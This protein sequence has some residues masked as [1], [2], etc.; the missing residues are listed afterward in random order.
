MTSD[1]PPT[2]RAWSYK[3]RGPLPEV[4][5]LTT[6]TPTPNAKTNLAP[7][8]VLIKIAYT[9]LTPSTSNLIP[10]LPN[11]THT[12]P[13]IPELE[14]SGKIVALGSNV[15][16]VRPEL[17]L[18]TPVFGITS[19]QLYFKGHGTLADYCPCP[20][21]RLSVLPSG[22]SMRD[23]AALAGN[24]VTAVQV[25]QAVL[26]KRGDKIFINGG[27]GGTGTMIVQLARGIVGESGLV[28]VTCSAGNSGL[29]EGLG[30]DEVCYFLFFLF[31]LC[32][33]LYIPV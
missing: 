32:T 16:H 5:T 2:M 30:A 25:L 7:N 22:V 21:E 4:L 20:A 28:V 23:G 17:E 15:K 8:D 24:G 6:S 1:I 11:W 9:G 13:A 26:L 10:I 3:T 18:E 19:M 12:V 27:S 29:V 31:S 14:F 33:R